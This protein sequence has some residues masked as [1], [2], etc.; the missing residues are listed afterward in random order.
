MFNEYIEVLISLY[1]YTNK[2]T[3]ALL[4][5]CVTNALHGALIS[6]CLANT[7]GH[8]PVSMLTNTLGH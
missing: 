5:L 6:L 4:C 1:I 8:L 2:Y 3:G 7:L